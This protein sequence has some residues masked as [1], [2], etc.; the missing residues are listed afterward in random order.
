MPHADRLARNKCQREW[1]A[2]N[3][4]Q[5]RAANLA[6]RERNREWIRAYKATCYCQ[7][8]GEADPERL[9]FH[10]LDKNTREAWIADAV[11]NGWSIKRIKIE[12]RKCV[13]LCAS[14]HG[15]EHWPTTLGSRYPMQ[16]VEP[17]A[18]HALHG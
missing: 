5:A 1:Y 15:K 7:V 9:A 3:R 12:I 10:H 4:E 14:C 17:E 16:S 6:I 18:T 8:C 13:V 11:N 2:R